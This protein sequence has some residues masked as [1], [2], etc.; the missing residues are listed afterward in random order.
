M[1]IRIGRIMYTITSNAL[2][3]SIGLLS[4]GFRV[5]IGNCNSK[6]YSLFNIVFFMA[7]IQFTKLSRPIPF[8]GQSIIYFFS[9]AG[10]GS[11]QTLHKPVKLNRYYLDEGQFIISSCICSGVCCLLF[12]SLCIRVLKLFLSY[13]VSIS[14]SSG[15]FAR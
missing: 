12:A 13:V 7:L 2:V 10:N 15:K 3:R 11:L 8:R 1:S 9:M 6:G 5:P 4:S 14:F